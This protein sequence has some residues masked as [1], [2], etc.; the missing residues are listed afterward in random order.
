[1]IASSIF[2]SC[3]LRLPI[4]ESSVGSKIE[5][6][7]SGATSADTASAGATSADASSA[8]E[9]SAADSVP[10]A[11]RPPESGGTSES[12]AVEVIAPIEQS[13]ELH[14]K[15]V[16]ECNAFFDGSIFI[17]DSI[18]EGFKRRSTP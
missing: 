9:V 14:G 18:M 11:S 10:E 4:D 7:A 16:A 6:A 1:M 12:S 13:K 5:S 8:S 17:G 15:T 2:S 3:S